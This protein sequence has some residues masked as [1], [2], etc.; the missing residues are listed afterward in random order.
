VT[1]P[2][3]RRHATIGS[4]TLSYLAVGPRQGKGTVIFLHA[5]PLD[6]EMWLPQLRALPEGWTG[7]APD[8]RGFGDSAPDDGGAARADARLEDY[9]DDVT[10]LMAGLD[11]PRAALCGCSM[12]GYAAFAVVRRAP[13]RVT[14]LLLADTRSA[15][16]TDAGRTSRAAMLELLDRDGPA[17]IAAEMRPKLVGPTTRQERP[18]VLA[19]I[20]RLMGRATSRGVGF[21]IARMMNRPDATAELAAF[22]GPISVVVG[23]EDALTPPPEAAAMAAGVPGAACATIPRAGHLANLEAPEAFNLAMHGWLRA[24]D[25]VAVGQ[26]NAQYPIPNP[27][28]EC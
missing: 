6:A 25:G 22:Q 3:E 19:A 10:A 24:I 15:A 8:F 21:A 23:E 18:D 5:F 4:R 13:D 7:V 14:G 2:V 1:L 11:V 16:D 28:P 9:A 12:G 20:D 27:N 26:P 17:A